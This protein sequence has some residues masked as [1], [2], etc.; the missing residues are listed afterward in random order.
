MKAVGGGTEAAYRPEFV[1]QVPLSAGLSTASLEA[2]YG[3][4]VLSEARGEGYALMGFSQGEVRSGLSAQGTQAVRVE[5]NRDVF[6]GGGLTATMSARRTVWINGEFTTWASARRTVWINGVF[7]FLPQ[8]TGTFQQIGLEAAQA[9]AS[10]LGAGIKVAVIDTG[11]DI[12]HPAFAGAL[13]PQNEWRDFRDNDTNPDEEGVLGEGGYGHGTAVA[14]IVLQVAPRATILP[15]RVLGPDGS[16]DVLHVAQA[17]DWAVKSGARIIN[18]SLGTD[19]R[20]N[21]VQDAVARAAARGVLVISSAGNDNL[22]SLTYPANDATSAGPAGDYS[23]SVGS[24]DGGDLKSSF[25]N[26]GKALE[27]V[28]PAENVYTPG[29]DNLLVSWSGTSMAAP[30]VTGSLALALGENL[31]VSSRDMAKGLVEKTTDI[32]RNEMNKAYKDKLGKGRLDLAR[33]SAQ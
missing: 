31:G 3:G 13:A 7:D 21:V 20:S 32:Y 15:L 17:I 10:N 16:G 26:Y 27:I 8:N 4:R 28:A 11:V 14:G 29:P 25:S 12:E 9:R 19:S 18:L 5:R 30:M 22:G 23:L 6:Q 2:T 24:V 33:F 1:A